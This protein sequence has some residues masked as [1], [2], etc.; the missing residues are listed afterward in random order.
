MSVIK[1]MVLMYLIVF[2][3]IVN[4]QDVGYFIQITDPHL[5]LSYKAGA[6][7]DCFQ[8]AFGMGCC[9]ENSIPFPRN[10][11][12]SEWGDYSCDSPQLLLNRSLTWISANFPKPDFIMWTGDSVAHDDLSQTSHKNLHTIQVMTDII[13]HVYPNTLV[14]PALG[15]HDARFVD[16]STKPPSKFTIHVGDIWKK[17]LDQCSPKYAPTR[18]YDNFQY[19]GYYTCLN[20]TLIVLNSLYYDNNNFLDRQNP[21][22]ADQKAWMYDM[23]QELSLKGKRN[24]WLMGH[25][26]PGVSQC[27]HTFTEFYLKTM[28][29]HED[30]MKYS[31]WGHT[32]KDQ[33][34]LIGSTVAYIA[35]SLVPNQHFPQFRVYTYDRETRDI[36]NYLQYGL[37]LRE[38][39]TQQNQNPN[40]P[41]PPNAFKYFLNY[42]AKKAYGL[43]TMDYDSWN[44]LVNSMRGN[45][46]LFEQYYSRMSYGVKPHD[47]CTTYNCRTQILDNIMV[48]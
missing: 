16:Q 35:P 30:I 26:P 34:K 1:R 20:E 19:G 36:L 22:P 2:V 31:F 32:H 40:K 17:W 42:E 8:G 14:I 33:I 24:I 43:P 6:Y 37:N 15:N 41:L 11:T 25:I 3:N 28:W 46:T 44:D 23:L 21:D 12:S 18:A 13:D 9:R 39:I 29:K 7:A 47:P 38:L 48:N 5:D 10:R 4:C 27:N 45:E